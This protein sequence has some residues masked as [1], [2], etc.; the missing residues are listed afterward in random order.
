MASP[1]EEVCTWVS[2]IVG[3]KSGCLALL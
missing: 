1:T 3:A 2:S